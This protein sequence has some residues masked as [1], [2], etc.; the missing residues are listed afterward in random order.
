MGASETAIHL[1]V[2]A[3]AKGPP[4]VSL[5]LPGC[6]QHS[7]GP[8]GESCELEPETSRGADVG[9]SSAA[10]LMPC[11]CF[12]EAARAQEQAA[13]EAEEI[14]AL[15]TESEMLQQTLRDLAQVQGARVP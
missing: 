5:P 2:C 7:V 12:Q 10:W 13:L 15:R 4:A 6:S 14:E 9:V 1:G 8:S 3:P 11:L